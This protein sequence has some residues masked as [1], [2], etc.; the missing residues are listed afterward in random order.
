[1]SQAEDV[2]KFCEFI[3]S[4]FACSVPLYVQNIL[5]LNGYDSAL[6]IRTLTGED[7]EYPQHYARNKMIDRIPKDAECSDY[8]GPFHEKKD[9]FEFLRGHIKLLEQ[10]A[11]LINTT[12][13]SKGIEVFSFK[14]PKLQQRIVTARKDLQGKRLMKT[15]Y[16]FGCEIILNNLRYRFQFKPG[17]TITPYPFKCSNSTDER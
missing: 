4:K 16:F 8:Y 11:S 2:N 9:E 7:F 1:M 5:A 6:S 14:K 12:I 17:N 13:E 3:E 10:I 15:K